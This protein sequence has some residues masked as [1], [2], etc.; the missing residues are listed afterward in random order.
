MPVLHWLIS[1]IIY[2]CF[3]YLIGK[4][5]GVREHYIFVIIANLMWSSISEILMQLPTRLTHHTCTLIDH[6]YTNSNLRVDAGIAL[7]DI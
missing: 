7:V 6:I 3:V 2:Q 5:P 4:Y 1:D